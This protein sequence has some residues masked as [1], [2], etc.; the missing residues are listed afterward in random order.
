[1]SWSASFLAALQGSRVQ[2]AFAVEIYRDAL[3][4]GV[5]GSGEVFS[6]VALSGAYQWLDPTSVVT[7]ARGVDVA[8][9]SHSEGAW[10]FDLAVA[11]SS[12]AAVAGVLRRGTRV[13]L[14]AGLNGA[15][16]SQWQIIE[17][18]SVQSV[19]WARGRLRVEVWGPTVSLNGRIDQ[20]LGETALFA[21]AGYVQL[22]TAAYTPGDGT[23][24]VT[25]HT[26]YE[27]A[28]GE[29][30]VV[31]VTPTS[32]SDF[33]LTYTGAAANMLTGL[34]TTGQFGTTAAAA[35]T[36]LPV[37]N[38]AYLRGRP[39]VLVARILTSTG[40]GTNGTYDMLPEMWGLAV[41]AE[42]VNTADIV[43]TWGN[44]LLVPSSGSYLWEIVV[45]API[46]DGLAWLE[47]L[48]SDVG[49]WITTRMGLLTIRMAQDARSGFL[50]LAH[51]ATIRDSDML[52]EF[53]DEQEP[54]VGWFDSAVSFESQSVNVMGNGG[55]AVEFS[56]GYATFPAGDVSSAI[57]TDRLWSNVIP[58]CTLDAARLA[59]WRIT[60]P[61]MVS[62]S[63]AGLHWAALCVG[64][65]PL[66]TSDR[67]R[68]GFKSTCTGYADRPIMLT[69]VAPDWL[70]GVVRIRGSI[71]GINVAD[72]WL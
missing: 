16:W 54:E 61:E 27:R 26:T 11:P 32:G 44:A 56:A 33:Y 25:D 72:R 55:N 38:S 20:T 65:V 70:S 68:G 1:M 10:R 23:L 24:F 43:T 13:R 8:S 36:G 63:L 41:P 34:S 3:G 64:D 12:L 50:T 46:T 39:D 9:W 19:S 30:G 17:S 52:G 67:L 49:M 69:D 53:D 66:L 14:R 62:V 28:T 18:G 48:L 29:T 51:G 15:P 71:L 21:R 45:D 42:M 47:G 57:L 4:H 40:L 22:L 6:S 60:V 31:R 59:Q 35:A 5:G 37:Y 58:I 2:L 7:G